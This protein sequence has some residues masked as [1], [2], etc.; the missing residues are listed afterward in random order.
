MKKLTDELE[1]SYSK[2]DY[3]TTSIN[4]RGK[5]YT[6]VNAM[7]SLSYKNVIGTNDTNG[8]D[9]RDQL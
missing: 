9:S 1:I 8:L 5:L 3:K 2:Y 4:A 6:S 7:C